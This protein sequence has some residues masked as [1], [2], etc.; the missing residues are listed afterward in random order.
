MLTNIVNELC[1]LLTSL[2]VFVNCLTVYHQLIQLQV[3][4][5]KIT[6]YWYYYKTFNKNRYANYIGKMTSSACDSKSKMFSCRNSFWIFPSTNNPV[7]YSM[8]CKHNQN[9][10]C[11]KYELSHILRKNAFWW[12]RVALMLWDPEKTKKT[13]RL[14]SQRSSLGLICINQQFRNTTDG[15]QYILCKRS[16]SITDKLKRNCWGL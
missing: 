10:F 9:I 4:I 16:I 1:N 11:N 7:F 5:K 14:N 12:S 3:Y 2:T 6:F 15:I 8:N 13:V